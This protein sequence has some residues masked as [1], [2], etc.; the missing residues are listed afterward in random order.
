MPLRRRVPG[1]AAVALVLIGCT[2]NSAR[3][4]PSSPSVPARVSVSVSVSGGSLRPT[5]SAPTQS[6]PPASSSALERVFASMSEAQ[7]VG[8]LLMVDCPSTGVSSATSAAIT[9][10]HVGSVILDGTT[11]AGVEAV[12]RIT[13]QLRGL[14][15][16]ATGLFIAT[17]QE[18]GEVQRLQGP[19][20]STIPSAVQQGQLTPVSLVSDAHT[21]GSELHNAGVDVNLAPVLDTVPTGDAPNPPIGDLDREYGHDPATVT[22]HGLAFAAGMQDAGIDTTVKHFPGLGR[23]TGNTDTSSGVTDDVTTRDDP[24]LA[25][26][27]AAARQQVPFVMMSTAIYAKLDPNTPAAFSK[28]IVTGLLRDRFGYRGLV[29]S[30]DVG[31]ARQVSG[32]SIGQRAVEFVRAGGDVVLTVVASDAG[33]MTAAL[34]ARAKA[35]PAFKRQVDAA[36]LLVLE[37]KQKAGLPH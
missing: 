22:T 37:A 24:Y 6:A 2:S 9:Q 4:G 26:Y 15:P 17:D 35:D 3:P 33:P 20:F 5:V 19:G 16:R 25:P 14:A 21:W 1:L 29:I 34:L 18:G 11:T 32:Y 23:V 8:Q 31:V 36:A 10:N 12:R 27:R 13:D 28:S 30:D 7:R